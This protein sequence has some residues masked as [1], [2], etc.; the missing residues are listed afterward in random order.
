MP[1]CGHE[2][3]PTPDC[4]PPRKGPDWILY[5]SLIVVIVSYLLFYLKQ[6]NHGLLAE[7]CVAVHDFVGMMW[8]GVVLGILAVGFLRYVPQERVKQ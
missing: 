7:F 2:P 8:W 1:K 5:G 6:P 4:H 3:D